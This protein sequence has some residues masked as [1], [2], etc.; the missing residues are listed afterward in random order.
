M[1]KKLYGD[2][3]ILELNELPDYAIVEQGK[4][5][6][7]QDYRLA[8]VVSDNGDPYGEPLVIFGDKAY[9]LS[10]DDIL[11]IACKAGLFSDFKYLQISS[12]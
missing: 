12:D 4:T 2:G 1:D 6:K 11:E 5:D 10:W 9:I 3:K 8:N 7:G